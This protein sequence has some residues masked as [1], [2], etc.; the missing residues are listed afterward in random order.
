[1]SN[2]TDANSDRQASRQADRLIDRRRQRYTSINKSKHVCLVTYINRQT[3]LDEYTHAYTRKLVRTN[4]DR[5][6]STCARARTH[7]HT[8]TQHTN[9]PL[10]A[11]LKAA[12]LKT[13]HFLISKR[14]SC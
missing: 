13:V 3:V 2:R 8:H 12:S 5:Q 11:F 9:T 4:L 14:I 10:A 7:T 6:T 1:M